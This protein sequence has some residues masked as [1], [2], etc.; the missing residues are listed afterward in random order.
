[1]NLP[2]V[3]ALHY[4]PW[5]QRA[6][7]ALEHHQIDFQYRKHTP[8]LGEYAL[9][10]RGRSAGINGRVTVPMLVLPEKVLS[11]SWDIM[12]YADQVGTGASLQ[13]EESDVAH[14]VRRLEPA[15]DAARRR[16]TRRTLES[17]AALTEAAANTVPR[18]LAGPSRPVAALG[19]RYFARKY[20]FDLNDTNDQEPLVD[21]LKAITEALGDGPFIYETLTAADMVAASL[22]TAIKPSPSA[23]LGPATRAVWTDEELAERFSK[24]VTWRDTLR[25]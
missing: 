7:W 4:S 15:Y 11:D 21:G 16:V 10:R 17:K 23:P 19:A 25:A 22:I 24:L 5:S 9:R 20:E 18:W 1:M 12:C 2:I 8:F 13:T 14:W 3:Y 6:L